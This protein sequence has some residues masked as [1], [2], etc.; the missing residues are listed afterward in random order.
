MKGKPSNGPASKQPNRNGAA[1]HIAAWPSLRIDSVGNVQGGRQR[2]EK[3]VN[4]NLPERISYEEVA[5]AYYGEVRDVLE[6]YKVAGFDP[7]ECSADAALAIDRIVLLRRCVDWTHNEDVQNRM[8]TEIEDLLFELKDEHDIPLTLEE[9][10]QIL[11]RCID[12]ARVR[13]AQ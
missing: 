7:A 3:I 9:I 5:P 11:D 2:S 6:N 4:G 13:R 8:K 1:R 12:I 10:D